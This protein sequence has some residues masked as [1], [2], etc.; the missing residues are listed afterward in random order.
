VPVDAKDQIEALVTEREDELFDMIQTSNYYDVAPQ[1]MHECA[2][3]G[4]PAMWVDF[5][6]ITEPIYVETVPP[7]ELLITPGHRGILDRFRVKNV[8]AEFLEAT[9]GQ[10][11]AD[12]SSRDLQ[13]KIRETP[14]APCE[15]VWGFWADWSDPAVPFWR[16]EITVDGELVTEP[17]QELGPF[18]GACPLLVG[19]FAPRPGGRP[20]G[21][22]PGIR[23]LPEVFTLDNVSERVFDNLDAALQPAYT[24]PDDGGVDYLNGIQRGHAYPVN[25]NY[26]RSIE[27][28]DIGGDLDYGWFSEERIAERLRALFYQDGPRQRGDTP[29]TATQWIEESRRVQRRLGKP[30]APLWSELIVPFIQR[31]EYIGVQTGRLN[32]AITHNGQKLSIT[33]VSPLQKAQNQD[34]VLVSRSNLDLAA[35]VAG[36]SIGEIVDLRATYENIVRVSGDELTVIR[37]EQKEGPPNEPPDTAS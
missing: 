10:L 24:Y 9:L 2:M 29:P 4:T 31:V 25:P 22:G 34:K 3:H 23:A 33:P 17:E 14:A 8:R 36:E 13:R 7:N 20:W 32:S 11:G 26:S 16:Y 15:V 5:L 18:A 1:I 30:A 19:R 28:I 27:R 35:G 21:R 12:L 37:E 6:H